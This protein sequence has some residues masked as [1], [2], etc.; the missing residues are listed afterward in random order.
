MRKTLTAALAAMVVAGSGALSASYAQTPATP[1]ASQGGAAQQETQPTRERGRGPMR[2]SA[3][4]RSALLD[5][6]LAGF[7]TGLKLTADQEKSWPAL[8]TAVRDIAKQRTDRM[9]KWREARGDKRE[10]PDM[11]ERMRL[12]AEMM[13]QRATTL[14]TLAD[15]ASPLYESLDASQKRR[16]NVMSR[17]MME[18]RGMGDR[19]MGGRGM[20]EHGR[21][22]GPHNRG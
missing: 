18:Q 19:G 3:E 22:G 12:R 13:N 1:G 16:F 8:E 17:D 14:K 9:A 5:A 11:I 15:A 10:R 6:R 4:D 2:M 20:G 7:K 21:N